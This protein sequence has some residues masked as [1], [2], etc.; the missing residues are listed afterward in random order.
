MLNDAAT[1]ID[2]IHDESTAVH[3]QATSPPFVEMEVL[4]LGSQGLIYGSGVPLQV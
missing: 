4:S 1:M 2:N 3:S